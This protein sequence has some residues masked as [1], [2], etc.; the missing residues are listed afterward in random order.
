MTDP[1]QRIFPAIL[2]AVLSVALAVPAFAADCDELDQYGLELDANNGMYRHLAS[3]EAAQAARK[4]ARCKEAEGKSV[5]AAQWRH[6]A[7]R[8]EQLVRLNKLPGA[9]IGMTA[10]QVREETWW[11]PPDK[12][13]RTVTASGS[14]EQWVYR[15]YGYLYFDN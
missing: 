13:N 6:Q 5:E 8:I 3:P 4:L 11:G 9:T 14:K 1:M 2:A 12:V 7:E 10:K 15:Y